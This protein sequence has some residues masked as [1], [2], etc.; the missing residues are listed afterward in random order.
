MDDYA[1]VTFIGAM[2]L[3]VKGHATYFLFHI[4]RTGVTFAWFQH[5][6]NPNY[7]YDQ[8]RVFLKYPILFK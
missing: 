6:A 1:Q 4:P 8:P 5:C 7:M 2:V 3:E